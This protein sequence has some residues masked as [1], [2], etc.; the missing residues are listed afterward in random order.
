MK[1][2]VTGDKQRVADWVADRIGC[3]KWSHDFE[4]LGIEVDGALIAGVVVDGYV[5]DTRC[6]LHVAG[7]GRRWLNR[8]FIRTV[9]DY[10]FRQLNCKVVVGPVSSANEDALRFDRHLGFSEV[11][12]IVDG[13]PNGDLVLLKMAKADC[14][15][16]EKQT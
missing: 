9:F 11:G 4:A 14:R 13:A 3:T 12:R 16:L 2:I 6:S 8:E 15:W 10:V 5:V 1:T 7:E